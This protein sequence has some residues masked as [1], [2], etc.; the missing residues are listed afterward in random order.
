MHGLELVFVIIGVVGFTF[1]LVSLVLGEVGD[2]LGHIDHGGHVG[3]GEVASGS[4]VEMPSPEWHDL[5]VVAAGMVG[6]GA[7]GFSA[8][9]LGWQGQVAAIC[10]VLGFFGIGAGAFFGLLR[11][12][13]K[14]QSNALTSRQSY[15]GKSARVLIPVSPDNF[16]IVELIDDNG[17]LVRERAWADT[18]LPR[19]STVLVFQADNNGLRVMPDPENPIEL[20]QLEERN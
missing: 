15:V 16:G 12:L 3:S 4:G 10:A 17:A 19:G 11:P 20:Q 18:D 14:Q 8:L 5:K 13:A 7:V 9:Q 2:L 6:F 1:L